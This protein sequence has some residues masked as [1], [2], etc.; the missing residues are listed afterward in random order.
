MSKIT[1]DS[2]IVWSKIQCPYCDMAKRLLQNKEV[3]YEERMI[4]DGWT[5][6]QLLEAV[7]GARTVPQVFID[8][9]YVGTYEHLKEYFK[10]NEITRQT[11][12]RYNFILDQNVFQITNQ[13]IKYREIYNKILHFYLLLI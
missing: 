1:K 12:F 9:E 11:R 6:E 10:N 13:I 8:D 7:P 3:T 2:N 5:R 4:G